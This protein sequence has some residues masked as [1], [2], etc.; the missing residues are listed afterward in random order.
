M[1]PDNP[2][3]MFD[4]LVKRCRSSVNIVL[5][6]SGRR[7]V[8][9]ARGALPGADQLRDD[10]RATLARDALESVALRFLADVEFEENGEELR[11][12]VEAH[13]GAAPLDG[14]SER[15]KATHGS[16]T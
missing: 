11:D 6:F 2:E 13:G 10:R 16:T 9:E 5:V 14:L 7:H 8:Q 4:F 12:A 3:A 15:Y 1:V